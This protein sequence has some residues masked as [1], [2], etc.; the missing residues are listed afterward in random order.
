M[1]IGT[2]EGITKVLTLVC[3]YSNDIHLFASYHNTVQAQC[4][5]W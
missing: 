5:Y 2:R 1:H 3:H 4:K